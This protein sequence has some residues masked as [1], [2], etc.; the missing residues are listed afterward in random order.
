MKM[1]VKKMSI[2]EFREKGYLQ[3]LNRR[4]LHRLGLG[5]SV[6]VN[7]NG[8]DKL[9]DIFDFRDDEEGIHYD[10][11]N[12]SEEKISR[13]K[14]NKKFIDN[15][16]SKYS[17]NRVKLFGSEIEP[18]PDEI[19]DDKYVRLY[20]EFENYKRRV[21]N[22]KQELVDNT[23]KNM[24]SSIIEMDNDLSIALKNVND[25]GINLIIKKL[26]DFLKFHGVKEIQ[27]ETYDSDL[28]E[29]ISV[30]K[31]GSNNIIEVI[32]KGY[33][34]NNKPFKYPKIVLG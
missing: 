2:S 7:S 29:V 6:E 24:L 25:E 16:L 3:E 8:E 33:T 9:S 18:I 31:E 27:T 19:D 21:V 1:E 12:S 10:L 20:A 14:K 22:E 15:E 17:D 34:I 4:F 32:S 23:T 30:L 5:L 26:K 11:L 13:F 28:H